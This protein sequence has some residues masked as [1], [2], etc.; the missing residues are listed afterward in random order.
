MEKAPV[1]FCWR[2]SNSDCSF[3]G[4]RGGEG[5]GWK[6]FEKREVVVANVRREERGRRRSRI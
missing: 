2:R 6:G 1:D 3:S 4:R 5:V